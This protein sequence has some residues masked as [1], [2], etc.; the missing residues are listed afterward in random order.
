MECAFDGVFGKLRPPS[1]FD[2]GGMCF[3]VHEQSQGLD[4]ASMDRRAPTETREG[5]RKHGS[6]GADPSWGLWD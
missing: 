4:T 5:E 6:Y 3:T 1:S 2:I